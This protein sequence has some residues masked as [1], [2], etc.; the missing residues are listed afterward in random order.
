[1]LREVL[2]LLM[3]VALVVVSTVRTVRNGSFV[4]SRGGVGRHGGITLLVRWGSIAVC[5]WI[6]GLV[7]LCRT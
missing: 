2:L 6:H 7:C 1:M 4:G 3:V 5:R